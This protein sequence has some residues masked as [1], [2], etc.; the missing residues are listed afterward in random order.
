MLP[1]S[2]GEGLL[3][4][5]SGIKGLRKSKEELGEDETNQQMQP[6]HLKM[7]VI[8]KVKDCVKVN[9]I[10]LQREDIFRIEQKR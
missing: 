9:G 8:K 1:R 10:S 6:S 2:Q 3:R 5:R 4:K 7:V